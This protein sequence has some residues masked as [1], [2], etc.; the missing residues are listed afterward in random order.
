MSW[1]ESWPNGDGRSAA[2]VVGF[3][4]IVSEVAVLVPLLEL[5]SES[6]LKR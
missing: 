5:P 1:A 4:G 2:M 3:V 6:S